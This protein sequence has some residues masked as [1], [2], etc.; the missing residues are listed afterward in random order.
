MRR[1][2]RAR[3]PGRGR[4]GSAGPQLRRS[5][6]VCRNWAG[7]S[8]ATCG[9]TIAGPRAMPTAFADTRPNWSR[10]RRTSSW[11]L[12]PRPW[13]RCCRRPAPCRS[14]S[15]ASPIRSAPASSTSL[16]RPGGN[17]TGFI[18]V[19]IRPERE[20]A[21]AAQGDRAGRDASGGPSGSRHSRRDRPVR[22]H[23]VR[24]AVAWSGGKPGRTCAMPARSSAPSRHSRARRMA[25]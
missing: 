6:K 1:D 24:G 13:G 14:C 15:R 8:A 2:R 3:E 9:S 5:C 19:R 16:A 20:M 18:V 21:G 10:S 25:A 12:A 4:S 23:P 7:P 11:P 22:R 17:V